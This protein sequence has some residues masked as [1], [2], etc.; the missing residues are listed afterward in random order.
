MGEDVS[1]SRDDLLSALVQCRERAKVGRENK[2]RA[3]RLQ[4]E[5]KFYESKSKALKECINYIVKEYKSI[6]QYL[7]D[8]KEYSMEMLKIAIEKAGMVVPDADAS[9]IKLEVTDRSARVL[10]EK[11]QDINLREGSAFRTVMGVLMRYTLLKAQPDAIQMILLDEAFSTLSESTA[12]TMR[13]YLDAFR[14]DMLIVGIEQ[15]NHLYEGLERD[16]Y[17]VVKQEDGVS[18][19]GRVK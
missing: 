16:I 19:V 11:G 12:A 8:K 18:T 9:G 17:E 1:V 14:D 10:N 15:R 5:L 7:I 13:D 4:G 6:E 2:E 3:A